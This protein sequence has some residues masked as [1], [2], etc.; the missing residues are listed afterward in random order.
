M[1]ARPRLRAAILGLVVLGLIVGLLTDFLGYPKATLAAWVGPA[2]IVALVVAIDFMGGLWRGTLGV[3]LIALLAIAASIALGQHLA[4]II[5]AAMVAGG[6]ALE[7]Y[8]GAR[9][10]RELAALVSRTPVT[11]HRT[12]DGTIVDIAIAEV[13][14]DDRLMIKP[15]EV[16]PVDGVV[17]QGPA[18]LDESALTGEPLPV[19][20][21]VDQSV[22]SGVLNAG[23]PFVLRGTATAERST[24]AA[25]VRLV[26]TAERERPPMARLADRWALGFLVVTLASCGAAWAWSGDPVRALAIL[27]VATPCPLILAT[28]V[29]LICGISRAAGRGVIIKGGGALER[30]SRANVA[31]FDKTGTLT[32]GSPRVT[33]IEVLDGFTADQV[34]HDAASLEQLSQHAVAVAITTA[35][36][37]G[38]ALTIP[39]DVTEN[40]GSGLAGLIGGRRVMVGG[41]GLLTASGI[42]L[43]STGTAAT[44][45]QSAAAAAW[46]AIDRQVAG[47][48]LLTDTERPEAVGTLRALRSAGFKRLVMLTGD[49]AGPAQLIGDHLGLDAVFAA[50][51]PADKIARARAERAHGTTMMIGDGINDAPALAAA[52]IGVAMGARGAAAAAE[53]AEIV[54]MVDRIDRIAEAVAIARRARRIALQSITVGMG[55]SFIAM[56]FAALGDLPPV[57]GALLQEAIDVAV[58]LNA[59][60]V[61]GGGPAIANIAESVPAGR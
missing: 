35:G 42:A 50:L 13:A 59:L 15:G 54:L 55:L 3:D 19:T 20:R 2:A 22:R 38:L 49:R 33:G 46:V 57:I 48:I 51:S 36:A 34:L 21:N 52:D 37:T 11:A 41:A 45:A 40:P 18:I 23:G 56:G 17:A 12:S 39:A 44:M 10:R 31:L 29:A 53:A 5:I 58:I 32:T 9:A 8:A 28:P 30:L 24:F 16:V 14:I 4:G 47:V 26:Q 27:V 7:E 43:P 60:R 61:L 25:I 6:A 1:L